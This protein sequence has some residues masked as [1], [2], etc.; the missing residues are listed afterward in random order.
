MLSRKVELSSELGVDPHLIAGLVMAAFFGLFAF[1]MTAT[2]MRYVILNMTNVDMLGS[3]TKVYQ[4]AVH[5]PRGTQSTDN[6]T[7]VSYPL[8]RLELGING[9]AN[10]RTVS[11]IARNSS[12]SGRQASSPRPKP[13]DDLATR[14]FAILRTE[15]GENPWNLGYWENWKSVMGTNVLDWL[16]PIFKSP[17]VNHDSHESFYPMGPVLTDILARYGLSRDGEAD[18][19][20]GLEMRQIR[21]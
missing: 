15:P 6:F 18:D 3:K 10:R 19:G 4:L 1:L 20:A 17:C 12:S 9:E 11:G 8:P 21:I 7:T 16:L 2:S 5:V 13:R 14:T